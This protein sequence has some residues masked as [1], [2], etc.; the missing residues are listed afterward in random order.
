LG[1]TDIEVGPD[2]YVH[3]LSLNIGGSLQKNKQLKIYRQLLANYLTFLILANE[4]CYSY[5]GNHNR[6]NI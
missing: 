2:G 5:F 6:F 4:M 3:I 1:I